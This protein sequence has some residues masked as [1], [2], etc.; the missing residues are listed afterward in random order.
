M[1]ENFFKNGFPILRGGVLFLTVYVDQ[2]F[3][4]NFIMN[5]I[6]LYSTSK[7]SGV[8]SRWYRLSVG[9]FIGAVYVILSYIFGFYDSTLI[10]IKILLAVIMIFASFKIK[11]IKDFFKALLFFFGITFL[12][13][14][15]S[16]GIAFLANFS[17]IEEGGVLYVEEFPVLVIALGCAVSIII[18][19]WICVFLKKKINLAEFLYDIEI[20]IFDRKISTTA[21]F[22]SG[23]NV[24]ERF[25]EYPVIIVENCILKELVPGEIIEKI[26]CNDFEFE[27]KWRRRL[28]LIPISTV[29]SQNEVIIG[30][31]ADECIIHTG[32][33][34][35]HIGNL[36]VAGCERTLDREGRYFAL[37]GNIIE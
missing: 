17:M 5:Y 21:L 11:N 14:G 36:V 27:E 30:F 19:K 20:R 8:S 13:G 29:S 12:I 4:E 15:A 9:A 26:S 18:I 24:K 3:L 31:R 22:D 23:H 35:K 10:S 6:I 37:M 28:R 16:I 25:T 32:C 7:F 33:E 2:M 1:T 34:N